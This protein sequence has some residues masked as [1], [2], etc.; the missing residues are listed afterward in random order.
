MPPTPP[1]LP[2]LRL[3]LARLFNLATFRDVVRHTWK[4]RLPNLTTGIAY[5]TLL[6]LLLGGLALLLATG[7]IQPSW[8]SGLS[9][10]LSQVLPVA[11]LTNQEAWPD[12]LST[13][14]Q[15]WLILTG[16]LAWWAGTGALQGLLKTLDLIHQIPIN[17]RRSRWRGRMIAIALAL[18]LGLTAGFT[19]HLAYAGSGSIHLAAQSGA[20]LSLWAAIFRRLLYWLLA[21]GVLTATFTGL[22]YLGPSRWLP[23][24]PLLPG[25]LVAASFWIGALAIWQRSSE[26]LQTYEATFGTLGLLILLMAWVYGGLLA[27]LVGGQVNISVGR[28]R[29]LQAPPQMQRTVIPPSFESFTIRR[30]DDRLP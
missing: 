7:L 25:A 21:W 26:P 19:L 6:A 11:P 2:E 29:A 12:S 1:R 28:Q 9:S 4:Y 20:S 13:G 10:L 18:G 16:L 17:Q 22:Y 23:G 8:R 27:V 24:T 3:S 30:R 14:Q 15:Q 5:L